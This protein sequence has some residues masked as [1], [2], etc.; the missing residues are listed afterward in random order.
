MTQK[1]AT[2][3]FV[4]QST[5]SQRGR[6]RLRGFLNPHILF[7]ST[8]SQRGRH[9]DTRLVSQYNG[10]SIH[11]LAKRATKR[12]M[13]IFGTVQF[14]STP[15]QRGRRDG[16]LK[17]D[18][19][20]VISIHALAKRATQVMLYLLLCLIIFQST[21]SQR[22]RQQIYTMII[23]ILKLNITFRTF[24]LYKIIKN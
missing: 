24:F 8:P 6:P 14:Q 19:D 9:S 5:P 3:A 18:R 16:Y 11:A 22:G 7:Q 21:P 17:P 13:V 10:I 4:F 1:N 20:N 23:Y 2:S 15:S 12:H